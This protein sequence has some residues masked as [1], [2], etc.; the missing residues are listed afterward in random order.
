MA[1]FMEDPFAEFGGKLFITGFCMPEIQKWVMSISLLPRKFLKTKK[2]A[3][4][5]TKKTE[6]A[7]E[8]TK[9]KKKQ[10]SKEHRL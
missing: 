6:L 2:L 8:E 10:N 1:L 5:K 7:N 9:R 4:N 3:N